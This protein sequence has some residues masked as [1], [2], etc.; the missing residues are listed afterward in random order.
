VSRL[1]LVI[2]EDEFIVA[3]ELGTVLESH[4]HEVCRV[5]SSGEAALEA[6]CADRPDCV[7][8]DVNIAGAMSGI[9]A[10][11][12]IR[13]RL[14]T[15]IVFMTGFPG[16]EIKERVREIRSAAILP[17]PIEHEQLRALLDHV[18]AR[19]RVPVGAVVR[20]EPDGGHRGEA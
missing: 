11:A 8:M 12:E 5:V 7:L 17:K 2:V 4:G 15:E 18:A 10:A 16:Y 19:R 14:D 1:R 3:F 13:K 9:D 20:S 6:A